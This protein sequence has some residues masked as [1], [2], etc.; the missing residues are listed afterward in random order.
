M[1]VPELGSRR[2]PR[3]GAPRGHDLVY[4]AFKEARA[5]RLP[6]RARLLA[7]AQIRQHLTEADIDAALR[8]AAYLGLAEAFVDRV[9]AHA[10]AARPQ[11]GREPQ[12]STYIL[13]KGGTLT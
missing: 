5:R 2:G 1:P 9:L 10:R 6:L 12:V 8:P 13:D 4:D 3:A 11:E 7:S